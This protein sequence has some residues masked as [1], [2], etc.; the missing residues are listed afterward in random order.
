VWSQI[1]LADG[2][3]DLVLDVFSPL[4]GPELARVIAPGGTLLVAT[5]DEDH[6]AQLREFHTLSIHPDKD[7]QLH[8]RLGEWFDEVSV[9]PVGWTMTLTA[10]E[11]AAVLA[12]GPSAR[13]LRR[14]ALKRL[15][16]RSETLA[17]T[18]AVRVSTF[19]RRPEA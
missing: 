19:R 9:Q 7:A 13:H 14:G 11:A 5:P 6:L 16:D 1:P 4:P 12:M 3:A 15:R 17:V 18:A 8:E 2:A 10:D